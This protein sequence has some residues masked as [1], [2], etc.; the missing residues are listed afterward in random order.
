MTKEKF[1]LNFDSILQADVPQGRRGKHHET[2]EKIM[3]DL[4]QLAPGRAI[5][6]ELT[7][8]PD[9]KENVRSAL[10]RETRLRGI[11]LATSSDEHFLYVWKSEGS[12]SGNGNGKAPNGN[13]K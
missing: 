9:S 10:N 2:I 6:I 8:L 5:K 7:K 4:E 11:S 3:N 1:K 12:A 13:G